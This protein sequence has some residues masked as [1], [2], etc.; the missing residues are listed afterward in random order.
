MKKQ[1]AD[2]INE[3]LPAQVAG[4]M[5]KYIESI[6]GLRSDL[7]ASEA[8]VEK[9]QIVVTDYRKKEGEWRGL[10][11]KKR[12]QDDF[13]TSLN[14]RQWALDER[15]RAFELELVKVRAEAMEANMNNMKGLVEK[16]FGHPNVQ[17]M[18]NKQMPF[19]DQYGNKTTEFHHNDETRT[20][21]KK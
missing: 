14:A 5:K 13:Q 2:I 1:I 17:I 20:E 6:E 18:Q 9:L 19:L 15:D 11:E 4:E 16:V 7:N 10:E 12:Q 3:H 8:E 21:V